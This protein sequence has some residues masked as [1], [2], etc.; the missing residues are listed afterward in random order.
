[1]R[2]SG[3]GTRARNPAL[4]PG[5][6]EDAVMHREDRKECEV[7]A[8]RR[9]RAAGRDRPRRNA[10]HSSR[11]STSSDPTNTTPPV[12]GDD[13]REA[14]GRHRI[15]SH[16]ARII[17]SGTMAERPPRVAITGI[18]V[19]SPF[20]VGRDLFW[21][22]VSRGVS[23][24]RAI[25][26]F[27]ASHLPCRVAAAVPDDALDAGE[28]MPRRPSPARTAERQRPRRSAPLREGLAHRR[29]RRARSHAGRRSRPANRT[30]PRRHRRQRR[31][32][33]R[34]RR[35]A[36]WR[37]LRRR[38]SPRLALCDSGLDCRHRLERDLDRARPARH[39]PRALDRLHELHRRD[40]LRGGA[41]PARR[42]RG[43]RSPAAPTRARRR[44]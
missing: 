28:A 3:A 22:R 30:R 41:H 7:E 44:A 39:Q 1:M 43:R 17:G 29:A 12:V 5:P 37:L 14:A 20:G 33:H 36:V 19:V 11:E 2:S 21:D 6:R 8:D 42:G 4:D 40:R 16:S 15:G 31:R 10:S 35:A 9:A 27:D 26:E 38:V 23:G 32:R 34:R 18:G 25:T 13:D 24:T